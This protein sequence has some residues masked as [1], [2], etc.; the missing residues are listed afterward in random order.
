MGFVVCTMN[1]RIKGRSNEITILF[2]SKENITNST[3][4]FFNEIITGAA[5]AVGANAVINADSAS[6]IL[7]GLIS[8]NKNSEEKIIVPS[9]KKCFL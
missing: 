7:N 3:F 6:W 4:F 1:G 9:I 8:K 2:N 5:I